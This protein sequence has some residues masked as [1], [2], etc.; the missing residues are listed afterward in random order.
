MG[1]DHIINLIE[2]SFKISKVKIIEIILSNLDAKPGSE[3]N[4][5]RHFKFKNTLVC[6]FQVKVKIKPKL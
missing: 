3:Y 6:N 5:K 2:K 4:F 1:K